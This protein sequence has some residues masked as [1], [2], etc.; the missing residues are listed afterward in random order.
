MSGAISSGRTAT[1]YKTSI[2]KDWNRRRSIR[3]FIILGKGS[4]TL[5]N[6]YVF[7]FYLTI[8]DKLNAEIVKYF[9]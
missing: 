4:I 9:R 6:N 7:L 1:W 2:L 5:D 8:I 3:E